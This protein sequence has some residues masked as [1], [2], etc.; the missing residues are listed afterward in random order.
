MEG[1]KSL[2]IGNDGVGRETLKGAPPLPT[3]P[4]ESW[5]ME[6]KVLFFATYR[7]LAGVR[8]AVVALPDGARTGELLG[9]VLEAHPKLQPHRDSMILAVNEEFAGADAPL[10]PGDE[11][12]LL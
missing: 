12:A 3:L 1:A 5:A 10:K 7:E 2:S 9:K 6:I 8:E 4:L 11:V